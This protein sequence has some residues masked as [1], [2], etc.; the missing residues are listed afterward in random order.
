MATP[1]AVAEFMLITGAPESVA[2]QKLEEHRGNVN[3]AINDHF[4][5]GDGHIL[6]GQGQNLGATAAPLDNNAAPSNRKIGIPTIVNAART[7]RP[8]LLLDANYR[9]ELRDLCVG[10]GASAFRSRPP[11]L[12]SHPLEAREGP[13][14]I[15][16][17]WEPHYQSRLNTAHVPDAELEEAMLQA[18]IEAS[19]MGGR[20]GSSREQVG[21][22]DDSS[23][24]GFPQS[25]IQ[26][27]DDDLA[28]AISLSLEVLNIQIICAI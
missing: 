23:D 17:A 7:F 4:L 26:Q 14:G 24:D 13:A 12:A 16:S 21:V 2:V 8:S 6:S 15:N 1:N 19:R 11:S 28:H 3:D 20:G 10:I 18:A 27:E 22:L 25:H 9:R 5:R